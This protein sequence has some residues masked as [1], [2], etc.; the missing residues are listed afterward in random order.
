MTL[1][2]PEFNIHV[3]K[4]DEPSEKASIYSAHNSKE[5]I[6]VLGDDIRYIKTSTPSFSPIG[7]YFFGSPVFYTGLLLPILGFISFIA[8]RKRNIEMNKDVIGVR[9]RKATKMARSRLVVAEQNLKANNKEQFYMEISQA[10]YGYISNKLNISSANLT[11]DNISN[12]LQQKK[13]PATTIENLMHAV[14]TCEYARYA[15]NAA[16]GD[17]QTIY[18]NTVELITKL[19]HEIK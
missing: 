11:K 12:V 16:S 18:N 4:G 8:I 14:D 6:K 5:E 7:E 9:E 3:E 10:L 1:P 2:A 17:L 13:V 15:P 19:E